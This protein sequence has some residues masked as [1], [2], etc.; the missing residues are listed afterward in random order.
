[1]A[2]P[3]TLAAMIIAAGLALST[4]AADKPTV[5]DLWPGVAPGEK[6]NLGDE[7]AE[8]GKVGTGITKVTNVSK[9]TL[10]VYRPDKG[11]DTGAAVVVAP[12][13]GYSVLAWEHEGTQA[14]EWL[15]S[16]GVTGVVLEYRVPRRPD[17]PKDQPPVGALQ[18][19]QRALS[20]V[21]TR[22]KDWGVDP[23][24][25][26]MLGFSAGGHLTAWTATN[27]DKRAYVPTDEADKASCR[28]DF[29]VLI[30]PGGMIDKTSKDRLSAEIRVSKAT[31]PCFIALAYN[32]A[33]PLAGSLKMFQDLKGAGA[34]AELHVYAAGGH[35]FG[36]R[37]GDKPHAA[38]PKRCEE[39]MRG[40]GFLNTAKK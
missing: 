6:G 1:M 16:I 15:Q 8:K 24:R 35:V 26:G 20:V 10:T 12:G 9:P 39:W 11:I 4:H 40:E 3:R 23:A 25:I 38:W 32:D 2:L 36:M 33:G 19:G 17:Q 21:R 31:P 18:D 30:Y 34:S 22:A 7:V 14:G 5:L 27:A 28:P 37:A 29:A 13:G